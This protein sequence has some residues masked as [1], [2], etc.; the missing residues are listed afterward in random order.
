MRHEVDGFINNKERPVTESCSADS[1]PTIPEGVAGCTPD[2]SLIK[3]NTKDKV[4]DNW[5]EYVGSRKKKKEKLKRTPAV[6][7]KE[8]FDVHQLFTDFGIKNDKKK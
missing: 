4:K 3:V 5:I 7:I 8:E 2:G 1:V 6:S